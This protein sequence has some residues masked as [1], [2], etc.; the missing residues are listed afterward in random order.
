MTVLAVAAFAAAWN[1]TFLSPVLKE[2]AADAGVSKAAAGQ[3]VLVSAVVAV[4]FLVILGPLSDRYGRRPS[5][6]LGLGAM[7]AAAFGSA[8]TSSFPVLLG[9]RAISGVGDAL[10]LPS[11]YAAVSDYFEGKDREVALNVLLVPLGAAVVAG[12]PVVVLVSEVTNWHVAFLVFGLFNAGA[13]A[14][15]PA[16]LPGVTL[17]RVAHPH[18]LAHYRESYGE[19]LGKPAVIPILVAAILGAATWNG[20]VVYAGSFFE[21]ELG[22]EGTAKALLFAA[23]GASYVSGGG[24]GVVL[25][26]RLP[27]WPIAVPSGIAAMALPVLVVSTTA[28]VPIAVL[29]ALIFAASRA[30]GV[31]ALNNMILDLAPH[32]QATAISVHGVVFMTGA[33]VGAGA[34]GAAIAIQ[35][36]VAMGAVFSLLAAGALFALLAPASMRA[37][38]GAM[39][40]APV[41]GARLG[42]SG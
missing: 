14:A 22:A 27:P 15:V 35:G 18:L 21:D 8:A 3:L 37:R 19:V 4:V 7:A 25:A 34:G 39:S 28:V 13:M 30:P 5:L 20:M 1:F 11:A 26:R 9:L 10:V 16:A 17:K 31:G 42:P 40:E 6:M 29:L 41:E 23:L 2:V 12:L 38:S 36:Y 24:I 32:S 33:A